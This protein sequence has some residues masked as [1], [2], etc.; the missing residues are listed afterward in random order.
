LGD[1]KIDKEERRWDSERDSNL[2]CDLDTTTFKDL[3]DSNG[4]LIPEDPQLRV[5]IVGIPRPTRASMQDLY[6]R[7]GQMEIC[8]EAIKHMKYM[9]S[10]H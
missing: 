6:D 1:C 2:L 10:Y 7:M 9:Q 3:L 8:Q 5:P 4:K